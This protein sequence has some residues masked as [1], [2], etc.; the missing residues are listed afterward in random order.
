M[1][2]QSFEAILKTADPNASHYFGAD[3]GNYTVW[4]EYGDE[5]DGADDKRDKLFDR[6]QISHFTNIEY[7]PMKDAISAA[8]DNGGIPYRYN[9]WAEKDDQTG[10]RWIHHIWD[11]EVP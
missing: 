8:L 3:T 9:C 4:F 7:S 5:A 11:C 2:L 1:S 6:I 10:A